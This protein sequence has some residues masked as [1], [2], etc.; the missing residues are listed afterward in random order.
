MDDTIGG[1]ALNETPRMPGAGSFE[2]S[3][4]P[5]VLD[6]ERNAVFVSL[7]TGD[8]DIVGLVAY[9]IYKQNKHDWLIA[10]DKA[11]GRAPNDGEVQAYI[12][13][14]ST[15]RRLAIYRHLAEATLEGRGPEV[16]AG[17]AAEAFAQRTFSA[18]A[19]R[20]PSRPAVASK[21]WSALAWIA[22]AVVFIGAVLLAARYGIPG[23]SR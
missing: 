16:P 10:F 22:L 20:V 19:R 4:N 15:P 2:I 3:G 13:G 11:K 1:Q 5:G 21:G 8:Q 23:V 6:D 17:P 7:V 14:E 18:A 12:L 9:S